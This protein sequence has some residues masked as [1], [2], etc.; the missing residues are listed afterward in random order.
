MNN[1]QHILNAAAKFIT[2]R[3]RF[4]S[5]SEALHELHWLPIHKRVTFKLCTIAHNT[6]HQPDFPTYLSDQC[7]ANN[8]YHIKTRRSVQ[9]H[10]QCAFKPQLKSYGERSFPFAACKVFNT[11]PA[12]LRSISSFSQFKQ[13]LKTHLFMS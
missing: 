6:I 12:T 3:R 7:S 10:L 2:G 13:S 9:P 8:S 5:A 1:L 4:D 11:L